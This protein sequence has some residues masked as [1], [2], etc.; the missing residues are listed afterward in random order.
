MSAT[1]ITH[2]SEHRQGHPGHRPV[3]DVEFPP[4]KLPEIYHRA[5]PDQPGI[6]D[7]AD[8]LTSRSPSTWARTPSAAIAMD[9][10]DGLVRG[11]RSSNTGGPIS[12]RSARR[13]WAAS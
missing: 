9:S 10:T 8:N 12:C 2:E 5:D 13:P 3:V 6:D 7:R 1:P 11:M 4:G